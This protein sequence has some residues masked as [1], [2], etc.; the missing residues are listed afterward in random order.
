[1]A[2][3]AETLRMIAHQLS[4]RRIGDGSI[5]RCAT[6]VP[7][8]K[9]FRSLGCSPVLPS[10]LPVNPKAQEGLTGPREASP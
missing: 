8:E 9:N 5:C 2:P 4:S 10:H 3:A 1:M 7:R 6:G